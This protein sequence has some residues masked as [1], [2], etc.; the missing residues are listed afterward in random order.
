MCSSVAYCA[1]MINAG[2]RDELISES[3]AAHMAEHLIFKGTYKR[4][5]HHI[6]SRL[7]NVGGD[8]NAYTTKEDTCVHAAFLNLYYARTLEL[9][10][11]IVFNSKIAGKAFE[12][13]KNVVIDEIKSYKDN[14]SELIF[15]D[16]DRLLFLNHPLSSNTLG[17]ESAVKKLNETRIEQ[18]INRNYC[19]GHVVLSSTGEIPFKRLVYYVEKYFGEIPFRTRDMSRIA[20]DTYSVF[21]KRVKKQGHQSHCVMGT[22]CDSSD[23]KFR[24]AAMMLANLLGGPG[25][26]T[27]LN[28]SMRERNGWVYHVE[29]SYV[30]YSD[31]GVF[32]IYFGTDKTNLEKCIMQVERE[33][34][35]LKENPLTTI[36]MKRLQQQIVGQMTIGSDNGEARILSAA[37]SFLTYGR[38]YHLPDLVEQVYD[39]SPEY[40]QDVANRVFNNLSRLVYI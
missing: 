29:A 8:L 40:M 10:S 5:A 26:N 3:G 18:F 19:T 6:L 11:D 12:V 20:P 13:E 36:Q 15:D 24:I 9:F 23:R 22:I 14:P 35:V 21:D 28:M 34:S 27:R 37:K 7:E 2:S 30:S 33:L 32:N 4:K 31:A 17:T 1:L 39:M 25:M 16:F 38:I